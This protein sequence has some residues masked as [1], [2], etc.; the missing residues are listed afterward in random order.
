MKRVTKG[1]Q[2]PEKLVIA[3][4]RKLTVKS[5][6]GD[7]QA[8]SC[9]RGGVK[10]GF[11]AYY[12]VGPPDGTARPSRMNSC[13]F[14]LPTT[15]S[16]RPHQADKAHGNYASGGGGKHFICVMCKFF[17]YAGDVFKKSSCS[18]KYRSHAPL[19]ANMQISIPLYCTGI[20]MRFIHQR[21]SGAANR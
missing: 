2:M 14:D 19:S 9:Y 6:S 4:S 7:V 11:C 13:F 20:G 10:S 21:F 12:P 16:M 18:L 15:D 5:P 8:R 3:N 1:T 17:D